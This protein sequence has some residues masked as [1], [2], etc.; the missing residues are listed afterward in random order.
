MFREPAAR[1]TLD[2]EIFD[3][4]FSVLIYQSSGQLVLMVAAL[5]KDMLMNLTQQHYGFATTC[6]T[7]FTTCH[8]TL[9][10]G[11]AGADC[12]WR[13]QRLG[14][15]AADSASEESSEGCCARGQQLLALKTDV[16]KGKR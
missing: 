2:V 4:D 12:D 3:E 16:I 8:S 10:V 9:S 13:Q 14:L 11:N 6:R 7:L 15:A 1:Q 5:I